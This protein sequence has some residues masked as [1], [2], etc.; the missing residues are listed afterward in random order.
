MERWRAT[1]ALNLSPA[2]R[3][4]LKDKIMSHLELLM[5]RGDIKG[6]P[7]VMPDNVELTFRGRAADN[8]HGIN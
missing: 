1:L 8:P 6:P 2:A 3:E 5:Q 7:Y 4:Q